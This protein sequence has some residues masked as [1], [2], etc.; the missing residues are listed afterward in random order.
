MARWYNTRYDMDI[1]VS[2]RGLKL[3]TYPYRRYRK[4]NK[5]GRQ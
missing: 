5:H 4:R 1:T 3:L 2:K